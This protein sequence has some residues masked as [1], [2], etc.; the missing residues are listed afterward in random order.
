MA[1]IQHPIRILILPEDPVYVPVTE[2]LM[3]AMEEEPDTFT[4]HIGQPGIVDHVGYHEPTLAATVWTAESGTLFHRLT[5]RPGRH[6]VFDDL[7]DIVLTAHGRTTSLD[8]T[9]ERMIRDG[10]DRFVV[11]SLEGPGGIDLSD[12]EADVTINTDKLIRLVQGIVRD[13]STQ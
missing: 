9:D 11:R 5:L 8:P 6:Q 7:L 3:R 13:W 2:R 10:L 12:G 1:E 4:L